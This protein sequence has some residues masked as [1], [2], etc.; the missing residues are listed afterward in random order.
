MK[1]NVSIVFYSLLNPILLH[2]KVEGWKKG[3]I[4]YVLGLEWTRFNVQSSDL[5]NK[6][7]CFSFLRV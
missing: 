4:E 2:N 7:F 6:P 1:G 5:N 3:Q